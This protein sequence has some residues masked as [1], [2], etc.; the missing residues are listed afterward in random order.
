MAQLAEMGVAIPD[1]FRG[2]MAMA[3]EWQTVSERPLV[4]SSHDHEPGESS[5][6]N[7]GV[8]KRKHEGDD[9]D[10]DEVQAQ[11]KAPRKVWGS[12]T[13]GYPVG[14]DDEDLDALLES[15]QHLKGKKPVPDAEKVKTE[16]GEPEVPIKRESPPP[17]AEEAGGHP[18]SIK[19]EETLQGVPE[20]IPEAK[21]EE[22]E[23]LPGVVF[24]KRKP[25]AIR[26]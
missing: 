3:G 4:D 7:I 8:R 17:S 10:E 16:P 1:E 18:P 19:K 9:E 2:E 6:L 25:K 12:A 24:K 22:Q 14:P 5:A 20:D 13:K 21:D 26:K 23:T 15:T 11:G